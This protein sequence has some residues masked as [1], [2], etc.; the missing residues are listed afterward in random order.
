MRQQ[1]RVIFWAL[2]CVFLLFA[3]GCSSRMG[4]GESGASHSFFSSDSA[5][6]LTDT[7][8]E[9]LHSTGQIDRHLPASAMADVEREYTHYLRRGRPTIEKVSKRAEKFLTYSRKVFRD[10]GM[11]DELAYLAIVESGCRPDVKSSAGAAGLWQFMPHTGRRYGLDQDW[12][13]DERLD[14]Y[15]STEAAAAYLRYLYGYFDDWPIA[16][17]AYNAG[18]GKMRRA[19]EGTGGRNFFEIKARNHVLSDKEQLREETERY[20]PRFLAVTKIMRN[21]SRLG[22]DPIEPERVPTETRLSARPGTDLKAL[23]SAASLRWEDFQACN[24]HYKRTV[25]P[26]DRSS[27]V[28]VPA[29][30]EREAAAFLQ[31]EKSCTY[32]GWRPVH[33]ASS[34][35]TWEEVSRRAKVPISRLRTANPDVSGLSRGMVVLLP[36]SA[37]AGSPTGASRDVPRAVKEKHVAIGKDVTP[38]AASH[39]LKADETLYSVA[40]RYKVSLKELQ[41]F[42][43]IDDPRK[44]HAG[45]LLHIPAKNVAGKVSSIPPVA[46]MQGRS[47][48]SIVHTVQE[49]D[50]LWNIARK[51]NVSVADLKRWNNIGGDN[52]RAGIRLEVRR[53]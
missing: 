14:P 17:A 8:K 16:I 11:P 18:E 23:S 36:A 24:L 46:G 52:L 2:S 53:E 40:V 5:R 28:Y 6:P 48:R 43:Q 42:N 30:R 27:F 12:W 26:T 4:S 20:V 50:N 39:M 45:K 22:F 19:R 29:H 32:A 15:E 38:A 7:E 21:L 9:I 47:A 3:G 33:V 1:F 25:T 44:V 51:Y 37:G 34:K 35:E 31:S 49:R 10:R 13:L 41:D